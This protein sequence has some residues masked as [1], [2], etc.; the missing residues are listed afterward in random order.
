VNPPT[1]VRLVPDL[2]RLTR[3]AADRGFV[4][5]GGDLGYALHAALMAAFGEASPKPFALLSD[6]DPPQLLGYVADDPET[7]RTHAALPAIAEADLVEPLGLWAIEARALPAVWRS[8]QVL[9]FQVRARPVIRSRPQGR[10]GPTRERDVFFGSI[11][12][13]PAPSEPV[14]YGAWPKREQVYLGWLERELGRGGAAVVE[15]ARMA[16]FKRTRILHR[17]VR[18]DGYRQQSET[19]G[20][21]VVLRGRLRIEGGGAFGELLARGVGRHRAFGFG[22]LL[23]APPGRLMARG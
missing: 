13:T 16:S 20:P 11:T 5:R 8:G 2:P 19:E 21:D 23:L 14:P 6:R 4:G 3:A 18:R 17:P 1:L 12:E 15:T 7:V 22:M 9:N 10:N